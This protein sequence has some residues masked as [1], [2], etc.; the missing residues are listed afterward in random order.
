MDG[1]ELRV[2]GTW[3]HPDA[4]AAAQ[5]IMDQAG[6]TTPLTSYDIEIDGPYGDADP[7]VYL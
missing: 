2:N 3:S 6:A 5:A 4:A 7:S 1:V